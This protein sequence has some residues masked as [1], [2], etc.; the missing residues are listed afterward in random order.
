MKTSIGFIAVVIILVAAF[1]VVG[2]RPEVPEKHVAVGDPLVDIDA[3][4]L[5]SVRRDLWR[6]AIPR[7]VRNHNPGNIEKGPFSRSMGSSSGRDRRF[8]YFRR[9]ADG[10]KA[11]TVLL[12]YYQHKHK[13]R[14]I[15]RM[16]ARWAPAF[17]NNVRSY[18][19]AV[20]RYAKISP[21]REFSM[22]DD[23]VTAQLVIAGMI[24]HENG[25]H[26]YSAEQIRAGYMAGVVYWRKDKKR[27]VAGSI[28]DNLNL[29]V[30]RQ[31]LQK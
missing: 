26:P 11:I 5:V 13:R 28:S 18:A 20:A 7:G 29:W 16:I 3:I 15:R 14:S 12:I 8:A 17:E 21:D 4:A 25:Y 24:R 6:G 1:F 27:K 9:P 19:N 30:H 22:V 10:I 2:Q 23:V 31:N